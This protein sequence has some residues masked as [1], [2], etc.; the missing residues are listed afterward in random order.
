MLNVP[1]KLAI[2]LSILLLLAASLLGALTLTL[3]IDLGSEGAGEIDVSLNR[4]IAHGKIE[5]TP[6]T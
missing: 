3:G 6:P 4:K 1:D 5:H 2:T